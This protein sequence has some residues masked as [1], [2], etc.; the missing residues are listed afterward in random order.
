MVNS[1]PFKFKL[2]A[3]PKQTIEG[4]NYVATLTLEGTVTI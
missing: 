2:D 4:P 3:I 1:F